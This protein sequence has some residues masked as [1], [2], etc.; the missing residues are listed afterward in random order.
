[1]SGTA[2]HSTHD[3]AVET[4]FAHF[5]GQRPIRATSLI[6]SV[7]GDT[8][9]RH[10]GS[11]WLGSLIRALAPLGITERLVRTSVFRLVQDDWL[12]VER[13]GR[14]SFYA[15]SQ[16]GHAEYARAAERI[17]AASRLPWDGQWT[18]VVPVLV[19]D[20]TRDYLRQRLAWLGFGNLANGVYARPSGDWRAVQDMLGE[21]GLRDAVVLMKA[22]TAA[23]NAEA[24][25]ET[26]VQRCWALDDL[27]ERY[28]QFI[29]L[30]RPVL[31][32]QSRRPGLDPETAFLLR[33]LLI[34]EY[35]RAILHDPDLPESLLPSR[36][37]GE[38]ARDLTSD[39]Y[40][41]VSAAAEV[42]V[43][44]NLV[45]AEGALPVADPEFHGRFADT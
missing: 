3:G 42:Y 24:G 33:T 23:L 15:F 10:G 9:S 37:P 22:E 34:H 27:R 32:A 1:M 7:F 6:V 30:F 45:R 28:R 4:L 35:R 16:R 21:L 19:P 44:E 26:L 18:F 36:W 43:V 12:V 40:R 20:Q 8:I 11:V 25:L 41:L 13:I 17:Y 31:Q 29:N 2:T 39:L 5:R 38:V 14:K